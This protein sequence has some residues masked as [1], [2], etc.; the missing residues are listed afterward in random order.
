MVPAPA[1]TWHFCRRVGCHAAWATA[2]HNGQQVSY[3]EAKKAWDS[4]EDVPLEEK[5]AACKQSLLGKSASELAMYTDQAPPD[6]LPPHAEV[7]D[8]RC[9]LMLC[10]LGGL[11]EKQIAAL[12]TSHGMQRIILCG[13]PGRDSHVTALQ[14]AL[15]LA[16]L[17][18]SD[19]YLIPV[20]DS[21]AEDL[22]PHFK[23]AVDF[24]GPWK[25][26]VACRQGASRSATVAAACLMAQEKVTAAEGLKQI[27][28]KRWRVWPNP[29]FV[30]Q[31]LSYE[32]GSK[33]AAADAA[34]SES[35]ALLEMVG[36]RSAWAANQ[37]NLQETG[38]GQ[39]EITMEQV[40][41]F[42]KQ[43]CAESSDVQRRFERCKELTLGVDLDTFGGDGDPEEGR[44]RRRVKEGI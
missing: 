6:A 33:E 41:S 16:G 30:L 39:K 14:K 18:G 13:K 19:M 24:T 35:E 40:A 23:A 17:S 43:A 26:L 7:T 22:G 5:F 8:L 2:W 29:G 10:G 9:N 37:Q 28:A 3:A 31:L 27:Y 36:I 15:P 25:T 42:W 1:D 21:A 4:T 38:F 44:K 32:R 34:D 20:A 11:S 12:L